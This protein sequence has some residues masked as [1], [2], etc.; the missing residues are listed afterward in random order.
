MTSIAIRSSLC[1]A[2]WSVQALQNNGR[3]SARCHPYHPHGISLLALDRSQDD[4]PKRPAFLGG[5]QKGPLLDRW[6][7]AFGS[8]WD[9]CTEWMA[10]MCASQ[11][12]FKDCSQGAAEFKAQPHGLAAS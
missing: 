10:V 8:A 4:L 1:G 9:R 5:K 6:E 7:P 2:H 3:A 12:S 11:E